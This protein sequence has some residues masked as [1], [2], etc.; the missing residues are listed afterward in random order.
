MPE[1]IPGRELSRRF[2]HD[3]VR[4]IL[5]SR[6]PGLDHTACLIGNGSDVLGYDTPES[7]DHEWGPR[8]QLFLSQDDWTNRADDIDDRLSAELPRK[9]QGFSTSF[10][11]QHE[12]GVR[13]LADTEDG[14]IRHGVRVGT[15]KHFFKTSFRVDPFGEISPQEWL[16]FS[17]QC[18]LET[19]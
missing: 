2:Y 4:P 16:T 3:A 18:L 1:F 9:F 14:P 19:A 12:E 10:S 11:E 15:L 17:E 6:F 8:L 5:D 7:A 13:V